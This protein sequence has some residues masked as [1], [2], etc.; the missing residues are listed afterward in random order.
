MILSNLTRLLRSACCICVVFAL[1]A[2]PALR[3]DSL[4]WKKSQ[5]RVDASID[6]WKLTDLLEKIASATGWQVFVEPGTKATVS[7]KFKNLTSDEAL[8]RMLGNIN[9]ARKDTNGISQ[10]YVYRT[11]AHSATQLVKATKPNEKKKSARLPNELVI[12]LKRDAKMSSEELAAKLHAKI[13]N[14]SDKLR[15][16]RL[17]FEDEA[18]ANA[19]RQMLAGNSDVGAIE[20][21]Y[22]VDRPT[23]SEMTA[24]SNVLGVNPKVMPEGKEFVGLVDTAVQSQGNL[25][26]Y[27]LP[28]MS[29]A[30]QADLS[31]DSP[32]HGTG[33]FETMLQTMADHPSKVMNFDVY[34][35][36][37]RTSTF[38]VTQ[39]IIAAVNAGANPINLSLGGAGESELLHQVIKEAYAKGVVFVAAAGN[40]PTKAN[41]FPAAW[42]EV[43]AITAGTRGQI[44]P[45]ANSGSFVDVIAP[46]TSFISLNG[47]TW[48]M[49]GTSVSTAFITGLIVNEMNKNH[50]T[51]MQA[52]RK[53][54]AS[55]PPGLVITRTR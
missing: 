37:E 46:G 50:L 55:P 21:N 34:G 26:M 33:M 28:G 42:P 31:G 39:G 4:D 25:D 27:L 9:Y 8:R 19:A 52:E 23:P 41:T 17:E 13:T 49:Q 48:V 32:M 30:G 2:A 10:L 5:D 24:K 12:Q 43:L 45:Y 38:E 1:F 51:P 6:N 18:A 36:G 35:S 3:G 7:V 20:S 47:Q 40:E 11:D 16:Y 44:D 54:I 14:R 15:L 22:A 29:L 53:I